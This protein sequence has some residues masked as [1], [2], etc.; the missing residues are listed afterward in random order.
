MNKPFYILSIDGGGFRGLFAAHLLKRME[1]AWQIDWRS[2]FRLLAGTSTGAILSA[3]LACGKTAVQLAEFYKT[4][5]E[6]IFTPRLRSRFDLLKLFTSRY[7]SK[8]LKMRLDEILGDTTLGQVKI[9]L[10]LPS[11]DIGN[12]CVHVSKSKYHD[13]F[14]RDPNVRVS[15][16]VLA[17]C[18]A[19]TYF[20]PAV[21]DDKY[22]LVDG[23]LWANNPS[24]VA[25]IDA[26]YRLKIPLEKV[27]V[28]SIGTGKSTVFYPRSQGKWKDHLLHRW[29]GWGFLTRWQRSKFIDLIFNLQSENSHNMLCLLMGESPLDSKQVLR[30]TFE[31]DQPLPLDCVRKRDDWITKADYVFTHK[32]PRIAEFLSIERSTP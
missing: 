10:I 30:L 21:V 13:E 22:Q 14:I 15:D 3:G 16:A 1:E 12:G 28:L 11:V 25:T 32:S 27:R 8:N 26:H 2:R 29:Q 23:G 7:S 9:P 24:L 19:P 6:A 4:H 5:G 20:D 17:S 31:S 18:A